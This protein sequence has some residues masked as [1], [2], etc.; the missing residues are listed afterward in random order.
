[1]RAFSRNYGTSFIINQK[2]R[3]VEYAKA[4][5]PGTVELGLEYDF[6]PGSF[7]SVSD[8]NSRKP[9]ES[10]Y[11]TAFRLQPPIGVIEYGYIFRGFILIPADGIYTFHIESNDGSKLY[12]NNEELIDNDG[13]HGAIEKSAKLALK[14]G[15]YPIMVKYFQMGGAKA[16]RVS[17]EGPG[18]DKEEIT[19]EVLFHKV[20][21]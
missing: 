20:K 15:E 21:E 13:G 19:A 17:W 12:I 18:I 7:T 8:L 3:R 9:T 16:L 5:D 11:I 10:G 2:F 1:M 6:Y 4:I 14:A